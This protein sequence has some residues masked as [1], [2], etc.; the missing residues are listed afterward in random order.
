[1][2]VFWC[3]CRQIE[4]VFFAISL[5]SAG[6]SVVSLQNVFIEPP[7]PSTPL[8]IDWIDGK[9]FC[10]LIYFLLIGGMIF[11]PD[12][13]CGNRHPEIQFRNPPERQPSH[14][15]AKLSCFVTE[16]VV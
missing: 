1:M 12:E 15:G 6:L 7:A 10:I 8:R 5:A 9:L 2:R 13:R 14:L 3:V 4:P 11:G 16:K